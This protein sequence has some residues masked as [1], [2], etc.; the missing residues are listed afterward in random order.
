MAVIPVE[1]RSTRFLRRLIII[2]PILSFFI[3]AGYQLHLKYL[4]DPAKDVSVTIVGFSERYTEEEIRD[5]VIKDRFR[6]RYSLL[7]KWYYKYYEAETLP[8]IE[9]IT[10]EVGENNKIQITAYEKPPI[11]CI[12]D[13]G[14]YLYFNRDGEIISSRMTNTENLPVVTGLKYNNL[15]MYQVFET[16]DNGLFQVI[17]SIVFQMQDKN[18]HI[19]EIAFDANKSATISVGANRYFLGVR[20]VYD[21]Q[22]AMIPE[23]ET[24]LRERNEETG[25]NVA[26]DINMEGVMQSDDDFYAREREEIPEENGNPDDGGNSDGDSDGK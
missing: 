21:V 25:R 19:D 11:A 23:V 2:F 17:M 7:I 3:V 26:Y 4:I 14:F 16:Q 13:M 20:K 1:R 6:D 18:F 12:Y 22:I 5:H 9:K 8:F 15:A 10:V 24:K